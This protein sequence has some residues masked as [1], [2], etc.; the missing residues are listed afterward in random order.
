MRELIY[1]VAVSLDGFIAAPD[2]SYEALSREGDHTEVLTT[3]Y[4]DAIPAHVLSAIGVTAPGTLF[5]TV[6]QGWNSYANA[7]DV[8]ITRP[9]AHLREYVATR[10]RHD[11]PDGV[12]YTNDPA[13]TVKE[14]KAQDGL[15]I[16]L[17]GGGGLAGTLLPEI[18]R[19]I[20]K[21]HPVVMGA[22]I[23]LFGN[24]RYQPHAFQRVHEREFRS[25]VCITEYS[26]A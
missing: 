14:L 22:G 12:T 7:Y 4:A 11:A 8:G 3:T 1:Y 24:R 13:A 15:N 16:Y 23:P 20:L 5:D 17:C 2:G 6:I 9:Y 26:R 10:T 18:D 19:L 21:R 25:G